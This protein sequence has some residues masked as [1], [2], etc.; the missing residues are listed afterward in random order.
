MFSNQDL[1]GDSAMEDENT[2]SIKTK[3]VGSVGAPDVPTHPSL[4]PE[5]LTRTPEGDET[6]DAVKVE[7]LMD[8]SENP[9][10]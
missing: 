8:T 9:L 10:K 7:G 5:Q 3:S 1:D 6:S 4:V 2:S